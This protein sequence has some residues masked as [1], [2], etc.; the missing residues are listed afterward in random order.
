[1]QMKNE[2]G[3]LEPDHERIQFK[4]KLDGLQVILN[5]LNQQEQMKLYLHFCSKEWST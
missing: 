4:L 1:M 2:W 3:W 5:Y